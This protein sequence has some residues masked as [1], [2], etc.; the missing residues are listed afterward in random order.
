MAGQDTDIITSKDK[1]N[2]TAQ[3]YHSRAFKR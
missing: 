3:Q 1:K 2:I